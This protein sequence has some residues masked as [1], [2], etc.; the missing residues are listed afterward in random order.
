MSVDELIEYLKILSKNS[1]G[2]YI[3]LDDGYLN[4]I[5]KEDMRVDEKNK[6]VIL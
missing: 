5:I 6:E 2:S 4:E 3:I 1:K